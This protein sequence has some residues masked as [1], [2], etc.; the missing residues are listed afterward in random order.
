MYDPPNFTKNFENSSAKQ[1]P[2]EE[3]LVSL[4]KLRFLNLFSIS[5]RKCF[6]KFLKLL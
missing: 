3:T 1:V 4:V 5:L 2:I 6:Y